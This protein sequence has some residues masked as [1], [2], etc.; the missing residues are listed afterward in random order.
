[1]GQGVQAGGHTL[2]EMQLFL[3]ELMITPLQARLQRRRC[4]RAPAKQWTHGFSELKFDLARKR[5]RATPEYHP[6]QAPQSGSSDLCRYQ[7]P[8]GEGESRSSFG[9]HQSQSLQDMRWKNA[10]GRWLSP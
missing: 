2:A 9:S 5:N 10:E 8:L 7:C 6:S 4:R 1:A 3:H